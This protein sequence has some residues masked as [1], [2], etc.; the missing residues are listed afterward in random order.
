MCVS[1][2]AGESNKRVGECMTEAEWLEGGDVRTMLE[3]LWLKAMDRKFRLVACAWCRAIWPLLADERSRTAVEVAEQF[4]DGRASEDD[5][6][7]AFRAAGR[8]AG[9]AGARATEAVADTGAGVRVAR[10]VSVRAVAGGLSYESQA[11]ILRDVIG[12]P[13]RPVLLNPAWQTPTVVSLAQAA[14]DNRS[15]PAGT[16]DPARL[17]VLADALEE[18]GCNNSDILFHLR[19]SGPHVR[20]CWPVD[21]VLAR[22]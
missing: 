15:L 5:L 7:T 19:S 22:E 1:D 3:F 8:T 18:A 14:Y 21:L 9:G 4:A 17:A 10:A 16:L 20:G 13:F 12:N 6:V 2:C 11:L